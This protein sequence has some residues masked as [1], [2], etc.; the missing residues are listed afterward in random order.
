LVFRFKIL[1]ILNRSTIIVPSNLKVVS[2]QDILDITT[3]IQ[4]DLQNCI[5]LIYTQTKPHKRKPP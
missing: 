1:I 5:W 4:S 2:F 3:F